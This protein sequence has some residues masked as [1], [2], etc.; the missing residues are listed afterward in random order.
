M[1]ISG[2]TFMI[3]S[4]LH[5]LEYLLCS[6]LL[7]HPSIL[8]TNLQSPMTTLPMKHGLVSIKGTVSSEILPSY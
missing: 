1:E 8:F 7:T 2:F 6:P 5:F 3:M 4:L